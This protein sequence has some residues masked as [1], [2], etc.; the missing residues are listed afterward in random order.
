MA[1]EQTTAVA[2]TKEQLLAAKTYESRRDLLAALLQDGQSYTH[3]QV[4]SL[5][6]NYLKG[7]VE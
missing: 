6:D 3:E 1:E 4:Q 7:Q 5:L 2:F